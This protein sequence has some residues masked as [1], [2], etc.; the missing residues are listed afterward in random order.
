A[1]ERTSGYTDLTAILAANSG[2]ETDNLGRTVPKGTVMDPATTRKVTAG[3]TDPVSGLVAT[4]TGYVR[5]PFGSCPASTVTYNAGTCG[6]NQLPAGRVDP[7]AVKL[8][9]LY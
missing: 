9:N 8:L 1:A 3:Q 2:T 5:D 6:L 4:A 7:A